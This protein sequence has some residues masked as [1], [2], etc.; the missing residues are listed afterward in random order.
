MLLHKANK[1]KM[2][3]TSQ[4]PVDTRSEGAKLLTSALVQIEMTLNKVEEALVTVSNQMKQIQDQKVGLVAQKTMVSELK[5]ILEDRE[6][7]IA[8]EALQVTSPTE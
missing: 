3:E 5:R 2:S 8:Q 4:V 7:K 1:K 6:N